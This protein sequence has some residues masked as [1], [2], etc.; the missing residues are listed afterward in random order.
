MGLS[1]SQESM[2]VSANNNFA[3]FSRC[4]DN[5]WAEQRF[6]AVYLC[7]ILAKESFKI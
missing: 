7:S 2:V 3:D 6:V 4:T 5:I 1:E